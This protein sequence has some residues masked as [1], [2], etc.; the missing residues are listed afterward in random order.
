M[1]LLHAL[2][3]LCSL[4]RFQTLVSAENTNPSADLESKEADTPLPASLILQRNAAIT[5]QLA[6]GPAHG[7]K[8]MSDDEGEKFFLD[9]WSF[10]D[11]S[12][13]GNIS[14]RHLAD[15]DGFS[16]ASFV[17]QSFPF[18][19][20]YSLGSDGDG[21]FFPRGNRDSANNL[22]EKREFKCPTG[23]SACTSI[24]R[25]D[26]CCGSGET[27]EIVADTG[28]GNVGC[29]PS[30]KKCS[31]MIG[32]CT[33]GYTACS[34]ALG[35]GCCIPGYDC[36]PGGCAYITVITVTLHSTVVLSTV[37]YSTKPE[38]STSASIPCSSSTTSSHTSKTT[39]SDGLAPP[40]R[41]TNLSTVTS[42]TRGEDVCPT[43]FYACSAVHHGGCCRTGRDCDTTSCPITY[44]TTM[45]SN[46]VTIVAPVATTTAQSGGN[47]CAQGWF[48]CADTVGG[49]CCPMGYACGSSCTARDTVFATTVAKEQATAPSGDGMM[50]R[51]SKM[52]LGMMLG[53]S[54]GAETYRVLH[55]DLITE[56]RRHRQPPL[57]SLLLSPNPLVFFNDFAIPILPN[58]GPT[59]TS[60]SAIMSDAPQAPLPFIYQFAAGAVAG[61]SE[62]LIM[63]GSPPYFLACII[64]P[65]RDM[66]GIVPSG[67]AQDSNTG[68]PVPGVDHYDGM[69]D[70]FR[71]IVKNEGA[72]RLYRGI[73]API[74]ME[75]PKRATKFAANDSWG[76]FYRNLFGA[77]KQTQGLATLT[78]ATAG[79]TE[80]IV[81]VP[82]ELVKI[83]LQDKAQ[84]HKYNGMFDVVKKIIAAEGP[85]AMYNGLES[86]MWRHILWNAGYFGCIFQVRAQLP[87]VEPG[88][89]NQQTRNDLIAGTIGGI[90]G[91][92][93]NT[94]MDV[95]KSRIQNTSKVAGQVAKYNWAW[96]ALGTV[97]KEEGFSALY[98]GFTPK[99]LRLGPGGGIL[100]VVY[101]GV[102]DFF[103]KMRDEK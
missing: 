16:P 31:G 24:G 21:E 14:E 93:L 27:C 41:P 62:I 76:A 101:T 65:V 23:T 64:A 51:V 33:N 88:N 7:V 15:E 39:T 48:H 67:R 35:G 26:R 53:M 5:S 6:A 40:A 68:A 20:S 12:S 4:S 100:L 55:S 70:C 85:L 103:R 99:V 95:V 37:T 50:H 52:M 83:R 17:A 22:F 3:V 10:G 19:P 2:T 69:F 80:A 25:S 74:L 54:V 91:T 28:N 18:E 47:R 71:K 63:Y 1:Q 60:Y 87:A 86:T 32:S 13:S 102:M 77:E 8:K 98:K 38:D 44:S 42:V 79:A 72:S 84:A 29:C 92:V 75:A 96:P 97:M 94:P 58:Y 45:I 49:G 82:F 66:P 43:G 9:Y 81:V 89:K 36:V 57:F 61:V 78:G 90:T 59:L 73:S 34:Q 11:V 46:D 56:S 30:W